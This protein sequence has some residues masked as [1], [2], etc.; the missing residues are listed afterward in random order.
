MARRWLTRLGHQCEDWSTLLSFNLCPFPSVSTSLAVAPRAHVARAL[1][2]NITQTDTANALPATQAQSIGSGAAAVAGTVLLQLTQ[3]PGSAVGS[4]GFVWGGARRLAAH[5]QAHGDGCAAIASAAGTAVS[6]D[7]RAVNAVVGR[8][9]AT[10]GPGQK[11]MT[12][13]E[14]GAGTGALGLAASVLGADVTLTV[15]CHPHTHTHHARTDAC[16]PGRQNF[17]CKKERCECVAVSGETGEPAR[18]M[19]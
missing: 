16:C 5:L 17:I 9:W 15:R 2:H 3:W 8:A 1:P 4:G 19:F 11:P 18:R 14:L 7:S 13:V 10:A 12:V 6:H